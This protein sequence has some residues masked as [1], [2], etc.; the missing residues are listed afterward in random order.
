MGASTSEGRIGLRV[1]ATTGDGTGGTGAHAAV[2]K[3]G[4]LI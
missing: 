2:G 4:E 3:P 1:A